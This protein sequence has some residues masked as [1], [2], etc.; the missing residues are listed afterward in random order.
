MYLT[1]R[2]YNTTSPERPLTLAMAEKPMFSPRSP[3]YQGFLRTPLAQTSVPFRSPEVPED[4]LHTPPDQQQHSRTLQVG[5]TLPGTPRFA[6]RGRSS[7]GPHPRPLLRQAASLG[8]E[9]WRKVYTA[10]SELG[11]Y[12][13]VISLN[14]SLL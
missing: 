11:S 3:W 10:R 6:L 14:F 12:H 9:G 1:A 13:K 5:S 8:V 4:R 2:L 7:S